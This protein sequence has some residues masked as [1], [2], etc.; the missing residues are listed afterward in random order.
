MPENTYC[1]SQSCSATEEKDGCQV[2][3][4]SLMELIYRR[5]SRLMGAYSG[6]TAG[7]FETGDEWKENDGLVNV[8][9]AC[10]PFY[11]PHKQFDENSI[12]PGIWNV[13]EPIR[14]DHMALQGGLMRQ[15]DILPYYRRMISLINGLYE[16]SM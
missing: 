8:I 11:Q 4:N 6:K 15:R 14:G 2:P 1:F 16:R 9:S 12:E 10:Y 13:L 5:S 7:G 3:V